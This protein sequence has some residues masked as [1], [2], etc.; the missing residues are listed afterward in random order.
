MLIEASLAAPRLMLTGRA[1]RLL[2]RLLLPFHYRPPW[3]RSRRRRR[4]PDRRGASGDAEALVT[5]V[6]M[7]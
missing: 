7:R 1:F 6:K 5:G 4:M 3:A 2:A